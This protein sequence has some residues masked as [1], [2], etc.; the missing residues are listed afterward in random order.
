[1]LIYE[2]NIEVPQSMSADFE[3]WLSEHI[4]QMLCVDGFV[5]AHIYLDQSPPDSKSCFVVH[6]EVE[7]EEKLEAYFA[8]PAK[9]LRAQGLEKFGEDLK[10]DRRVLAR[11]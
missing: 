1:M 2:V 5:G 9:Q 3:G 8:G 10:V 6:Y 7:S 11:Q 4:E